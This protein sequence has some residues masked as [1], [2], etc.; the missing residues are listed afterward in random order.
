MFVHD[1]ETSAAINRDQ[2]HTST[3]ENTRDLIKVD[4]AG[5][6]ENQRA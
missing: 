3:S 4:M 2:T 6:L 5:F 1:L